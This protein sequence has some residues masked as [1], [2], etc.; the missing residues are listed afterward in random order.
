MGTGEKE[1]PVPTPRWLV[2]P[3]S[4]RMRF[5]LVNHVPSL[6]PSSTIWPHQPYHRLRSIHGRGSLA[7]F[8]QYPSRCSLS[9]TPDFPSRVPRAPSQLSENL[10]PPASLPIAALPGFVP[11]WIS[12][13]KRRVVSLRR[14][15]CAITTSTSAEITTRHNVHVS[16]PSRDGPCSSRQRG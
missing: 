4:S 16:R 6:F 7:R 9:I 2:R 14:D 13:P 15:N 5:A 11:T 8:L 12:S 10:L 1:Q 3:L